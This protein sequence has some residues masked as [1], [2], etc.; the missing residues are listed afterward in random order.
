MVVLHLL[1]KAEHFAILPC[2]IA[3]CGP[4]IAAVKTDTQGATCRAE[5]SVQTKEHGS[6]QSFQGLKLSRKGPRR[7][8]HSL[9]SF[10]PNDTYALAHV[11]WE[12]SCSRPPGCR[13]WGRGA[14]RTRAAAG[15]WRGQ[16]PCEAKQ[17]HTV[18]THRL[19]RSF[20]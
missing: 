1:L 6:S 7:Q 11:P 15:P 4:E 2:K 18:A 5:L 8:R 10:P 16:G 9:D 17:C 20:P 12:K 13:T 19:L 3:F 14:A